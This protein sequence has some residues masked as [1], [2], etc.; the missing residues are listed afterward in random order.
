MTNVSG[1][2]SISV[3]TGEISVSSGILLSTNAAQPA[4]SSRE[5]VALVHA[6]MTESVHSLTY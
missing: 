1:Q 5:H 4:T 3:A 6:S 2:M